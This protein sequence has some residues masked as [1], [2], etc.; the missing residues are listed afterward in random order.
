MLVVELDTVE[1]LIAALTPLKIKQERSEGFQLKRPL[2]WNGSYIFRGQANSDWGLTPKIF[3]KRQNRAF[4]EVLLDEIHLFDSFTEN[5]KSFHEKNIEEDELIR[6][7][8]MYSHMLSS[9]AQLPNESH[10][11]DKDT[12]VFPVKEMYKPLAYMQHIGL[13]TRLLDWS[14]SP[15]VA[16]YFAASDYSQHELYNPKSKISV[17]AFGA[18]SYAT[19]SFSLEKID[20]STIGNKRMSLQKGCFTVVKDV[21]DI[22]ETPELVVE[23]DITKLNV[24]DDLNDDMIS[25]CQFNLPAKLRPEL[26]AYLDFLGINALTL[27]DPTY[28]LQKGTMDKLFINYYGDSQLRKGGDTSMMFDL[29]FNED[30]PQ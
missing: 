25:F 23:K 29:S 7:R 1:E 17:F 24:G 30:P 21:F 11:K 2:N 14:Y 26:L 3:R 16:A 8:E 28:G 6:A 9:P 27:F 15:L 20:V 19:E 4:K 10:G 13:K 22:S 12:R 18:N 5:I